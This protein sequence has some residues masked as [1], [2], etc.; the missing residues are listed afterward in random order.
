M[1][2]FGYKVSK[3]GFSIGTEFEQFENFFF[4]PETSITLEDL[5]TNSTASTQLKKQE[6]S[7]ED[8]YFNYG[9]NYDLRDST[10]RPT[11]GNKVSF[12]QNLPLISTNNEI[13]NTLIFTQYKKLNETS[14]MIG[15]A[16]VYF[17]A[18]NSIDGS[19]VRVSK[20]GQVPYNRLRGF[21]RGKIGPTDNK[22]YIGGNYVSS[23]NLS[24]NIPGILTTVENVDISYFIDVANVW[25]VDYDSSIDDSNKIRSATGIG[26]NLLTPVGPLS[27]SLSQPITKT[28]SDKTETF[29]FNIGTTF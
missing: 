24:T 1:T 4:S 10:Y 6:G 27:F 17:K 3:T 18:I 9:L 19:D 15:K 12:F 23:L 20:R 22:D 14:D 11:S 2:D 13:S 5:E 21:E 29:R 7:Y 16:S 28:S 26:M 8:F 25:G